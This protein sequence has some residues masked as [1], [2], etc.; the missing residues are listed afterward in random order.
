[1]SHH[2]GF[3]AGINKG[4]APSIL[5]PGIAVNPALRGARTRRFRSPNGSSE[6]DRDELGPLQPGNGTE[7]PLCGASVHATDARPFLVETKKPGAAC[8]LAPGLPEGKKCE[9]LTS[10]KN[11]LPADPP[12][13][14][15]EQP[16]NHDVENRQE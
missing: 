6:A 13:I 4:N 15:G 10:P 8:G 7:A 11:K 16:R 3:S 9:S 12:K 1:M 5:R 14:A 2:P